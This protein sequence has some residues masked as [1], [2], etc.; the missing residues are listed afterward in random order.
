MYHCF[1]LLN[2]KGSLVHEVLLFL[3]V[4]VLYFSLREWFGGRPLLARPLGGER[5]GNL[6]DVGPAA[7]SWRFTVY[8][9][10]ENTIYG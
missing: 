6:Q 8:F 7:T 4:R 9:L 3:R 1:V 5:H 2:I 10:K